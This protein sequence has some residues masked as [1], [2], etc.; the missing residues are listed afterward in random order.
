[1]IDIT[2]ST[3][4]NINGDEIIANGNNPQMGSM[5][6]QTFMDANLNATVDKDAVSGYVRP[7]LSLISAF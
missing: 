6:P 2:N 1:M 5:V 3:N 4:M 7:L